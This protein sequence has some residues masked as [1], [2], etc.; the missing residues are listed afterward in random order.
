[1]VS[2]T[3]SRRVIFAELV[4]ARERRSVSVTAILQIIPGRAQPEI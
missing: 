4:S 3:V 1:M 2:Q